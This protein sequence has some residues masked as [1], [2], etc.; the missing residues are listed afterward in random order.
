MENPVGLPHFEVFNCTDYLN[1]VGTDILARLVVKEALHDSC[2]RFPEPAC[3]PGTRT[4]IVEELRAW[5]I[6][7]T[8]ES[9]LLWLHGSAGVGKSAI[10]QMFAGECQNRNQL[11]ASFFFKRG[12]AR[13]GTWK[14]LFTTIAYQLATSVSE[15]LPPMQEVVERDKLI[16]GRSM[17]VQFQRLIVE[18][19]RNVPAPHPHPTIVLDGLD[20]CEDHRIQQQILRLF[21]EAIR[22][23][24]LPIR[25]LIASRPEP[26]LQE[27][28]ETGDALGICR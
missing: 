25:L 26:H 6:D 10:A 22:V 9:T 5:S 20:E 13:R 23:N 16:D 1:I 28:L 2:E 4:S 27:V 7:T 11:G 18:P 12:D 17:A 24:Q 3:H 21:I 14:G 19:F 8:P 15:V